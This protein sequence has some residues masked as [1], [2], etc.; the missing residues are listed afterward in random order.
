VKF[1][2]TINMVKA[3]LAWLLG[4]SVSISAGWVATQT[5]LVQMSPVVVGIIDRNLII[6]FDSFRNEHDALR[7]QPIEPLKL[8]VR[9]ARV[10]DELCVVTC[11][12][13]PDLVRAN[14]CLTLHDICVSKIFGDQ[15]D[16][17]ANSLT[18]FEW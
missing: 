2:V 11:L 6:C 7:T 16:E 14:I 17:L 12:T 15:S 4:L 13:L 8:T 9:Y 10:I 3:S 5:G 1:L 18:S